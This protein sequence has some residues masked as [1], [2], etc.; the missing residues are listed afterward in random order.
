MRRWT[1]YLIAAVTTALLASPVAAV[2]TVPSPAAAATAVPAPTA[3]RPYSD[4]LWSP[5]RT[6]A[7]I[8][9]VRTNCTNGSGNAYH[10]NWAID[11]IG[12]LG[13]PV[14]AAG[15]GVFHVGEW[16]PGCVTTPSA[17][18]RGTWAWV[19]HGG[20]RVTRYH[21]LDSFVAKEGQRVTPATVIGRMGHAGDIAPCTTNYLHFEVRQGGVDGTRV[22]PKT[23]AVCLPSGK[24]AMPGIFGATSFDKLAP[25]VHSVPASTS[26]CVGTPWT[27]TPA[28]PALSVKRKDRAVTLSWARPAAGATQVV[29]TQEVWSPSLRRYGK[30]VYRYLSGGPS[31]HTWTGLSNGRTYRFKV[32]VK[33]GAGAS[34]WSATKTAIPAGLPKAPKSPRF[35]TAPTRDYVHYGWWKADGNG[36]AVTQ[37][38]AQVRCAKPGRSYGAW[39]EVRTGA[40]TFYTNFRSLKGYSTCQVRVRSVNPVGLSPWSTTSKIRKRT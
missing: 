4:P 9:C 27:A 14:Y 37:Y 18:E 6:P 1:R 32:A 15:T 21:H 17:I 12:N 2:T 30:P 25:R 20:G 28:K 22:E 10:G 35:L 19:D 7:K 8:S 23:L 3:T 5:L 24:A 11:F 26:A 39:R 38:R 31:S 13:D 29:L 16:R 40:G 36:A 34:A 33:N